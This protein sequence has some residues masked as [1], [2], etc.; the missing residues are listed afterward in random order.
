MPLRTSLLL[1]GHNNKAPG[2]SVGSATTRIR[3]MVMSKPTSEDHQTQESST[4]TILKKIIGRTHIKEET[5]SLIEVI[6]FRAKGYEK[7][8]R[9]YGR[10]SYWVRILVSFLSAATTVALGI[11]I[12][13][14]KVEYATNVALVCSAFVT[15]LIS[16]EN[17]LGQGER[18]IAAEKARRTIRRMAYEIFCLTSVRDLTDV[19]RD[20][21][22]QQF[23]QAVSEAD[24]GSLSARKPL[25]TPLQEA[26]K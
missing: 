21:F 25:T 24:S 3:S 9:R 22:S 6:L 11:K 8:A 1:D 10:S 18:A 20:T 5:N 4:T 26:R 7:D 13:D 15:I 19:E 12:N 23:Y 2:I 17:T 14:F 16:L